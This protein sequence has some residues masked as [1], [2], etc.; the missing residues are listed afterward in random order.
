MDTRTL[1]LQ[2][3]CK[4]LFLIQISCKKISNK[5]QKKVLKK[6]IQQKLLFLSIFQWQKNWKFN[7]LY[8]EKFF[9]FPN[10]FLFTKWFSKNKN[11]FFVNSKILYG[12]KE[13]KIIG[14]KFSIIVIFCCYHK[15]GPQNNL[16][17]GND[18]IVD[19][20]AFCTSFGIFSTK[21]LNKMR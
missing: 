9:N 12:T 21:K 10:S 2:K 17:I 20:I 11:I 13:R 16:K 19:K 15:C 8:S 3:L 14:L 6:R 1:N 5:S 4:I 7:N 18:Y